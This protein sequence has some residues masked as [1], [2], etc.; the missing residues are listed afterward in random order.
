MFLYDFEWVKCNSVIGY[1][2]YKKY[3][4]RIVHKKYL[5]ALGEEIFFMNNT[6]LSKFKTYQLAVKNFHNCH[7]LQLPYFLKNQ[8][9]RASS[10]IALNLAEGSN[11]NTTKDKLRFYNY[12]I[13]SLREVQASLDLANIKVNKNSIFDT[14]GAHLY[15]LI[16]STHSK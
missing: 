9:P 7:Q 10:S 15:K 16:K 8:I 11:R 4:V 14:L 2:F 12:S 1:Q 5:P 3:I 13:S 6:Q